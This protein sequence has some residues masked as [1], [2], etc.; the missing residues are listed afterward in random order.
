M[1]G[2]EQ[3]EAG[4]DDAAWNASSPMVFGVG[5]DGRLGIDFTPGDPEMFQ[6]MLVASTAAVNAYR[7]EHPDATVADIMA[8][9]IE[10]GAAV[11]DGSG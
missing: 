6:R 10:A 5:S 8:V 4:R 9:S 11:L 1:G 3:S 7:A 2:T